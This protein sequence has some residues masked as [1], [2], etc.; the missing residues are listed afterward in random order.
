MALMVLSSRQGS[1][2]SFC[3]C[4]WRV[5]YMKGYHMSQSLSWDATHVAS[6]KSTQS[7]H[8]LK[9]LT[10]VVWPPRAHRR[11]RDM[12]NDTHLAYHRWGQFNEGQLLQNTFQMTSRRCGLRVNIKQI[13]NKVRGKSCSCRE[14]SFGILPC[15]QPPAISGQLFCATQPISTATGATSIFA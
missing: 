4:R 9:R 7:N 1:T 5:T 8:E 14:Y 6:W 10:N 15:P 2:P 12:C 13:T 11:T 3:D